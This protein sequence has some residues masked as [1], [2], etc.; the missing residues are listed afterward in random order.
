MILQLKEKPGI[1]TSTIWCLISHGSPK[2]EERE[3]SVN[4]QAMFVS[5]KS[6]IQKLRIG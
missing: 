6:I 2:K 1:E 3:K 5:C 4:H